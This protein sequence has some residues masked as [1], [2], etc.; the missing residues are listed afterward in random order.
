MQENWIGRSEG[1]RM[2]FPLEGLDESIEVFTTR[3]DTIYG[4]T[5]MVLS[6]EHPLVEQLVDGTEYAAAA[7]E[8]SREDAPHG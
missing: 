7:Q 3:P 4:A 2:R 8:F 5:F 6:P 1:L